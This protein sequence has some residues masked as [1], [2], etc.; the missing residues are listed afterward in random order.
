MLYLHNAWYESHK[1]GTPHPKFGVYHLAEIHDALRMSCEILA[2]E[3]SADADPAMAAE[4]VVDLIKAELAS[5]RQASDIKIV[6]ASKGGVIAMLASTAL[7]EPDLRWV[8]VGGGIA[9][10]IETYAPRLSGRVLSI[11]EASD[12]VGHSFPKNTPLTASVTEFREVRTD[13]GLDPRLSVQCQPRLGQAGSRLVATGRRRRSGIK[14]AGL[15]SPASP[16]PNV[17]N[18]GRYRTG[19]VNEPLL[20]L[21]RIA[22]F[23]RRTRIARV[24]GLFRGAGIAGLLGRARIARFRLG[25][26]TG[27]ATGIGRR[28]DRG[29]TDGN[30]QG[31]G[32]AQK[33]LCRFS[34]ANCSSMGCGVLRE[35]RY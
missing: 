31:S 32:G 30:R 19:A 16:K 21:A 24:A 11:Y 26:L 33:R 22:G 15:E 18:A 4:E 34:H 14:K 10:A 13:T 35:E 28:R 1:D 8:I 29:N 7:G 6:G 5:G 17:K 2:P 9:S 23:L 25:G 12:S 3:R 20:G 27:I